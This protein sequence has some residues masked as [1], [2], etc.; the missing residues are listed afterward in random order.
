M[1]SLLPLV[2]M[3]I[4]HG[5]QQVVGSADGVEVA[6][7]VEVDVLHGNDLGITAASGAAL[8]A[9]HGAQ[10]GLTQ[11]DQN[12]LAQLLHAVGQTHGSGGLAFAGRSG[13]D[14]GDQDQLALT[15]LGLVEDIV[16]PLGL[17]VAVLL[18][19]L[20]STPAVLAISVMCSMGVSCAISMSDLKLISLSFFLRL[21]PLRIALVPG[22]QTK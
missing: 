4:Q 17:V 14:S 20:S 6:G 13:V 5:G 21:P 8:D 19:V 18:Q 10:G 7:E 1:P 11:G 9:E 15:L 3:V 2:N 22:K 12:V 16:I